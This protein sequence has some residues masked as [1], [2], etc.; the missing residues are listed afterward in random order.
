MSPVVPSM[1]RHV[2]IC[3]GDMEGHA[4]AALLVTLLH[5]VRFVL[6][7]N[8]V[9]DASHLLNRQAEGAE[10]AE[11]IGCHFHTDCDA[12]LRSCSQVWCG[13]S[14]R[15]T[16]RIHAHPQAVRHNSLET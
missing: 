10:T 11:K 15:A 9:H 14:A 6:A 4:L 12:L 2:P 16:H 3:P 5:P 13:V 7:F 1:S 8:E